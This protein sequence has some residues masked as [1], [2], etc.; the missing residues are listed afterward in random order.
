MVNKPEDCG[1]GSTANLSEDQVG[2]LQAQCEACE[3]AT[4]FLPTEEYFCVN[5]QRTLP[6]QGPNPAVE[7]NLFYGIGFVSIVSDPIAEQTTV[8]YKLCFCDANDNTGAGISHITFE[9]CPGAP[10]P[11]SALVGVQEA[12]IEADDPFFEF[13]NFK[14]E[15]V[16]FPAEGTCTTVTLVYEGV[17]TIDDLATNLD[18]GIKIGS[19]R[20]TTI[21]TGTV[22]GLPILCPTDDPPPPTPCEETDIW[23]EACVSADVTVTGSADVGEVEVSCI[24]P[25]TLGPCPG[26]P[27]PSMFT[28]HQRLCLKVP[29]SFTAVAEANNETVTIGEPSEESCIPPTNGTG[30]AAYL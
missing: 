5:I 2:I 30:R 1:C 9:L 17:F 26:T 3:G 27:G 6:A 14:I 11:I 20:M 7:Q 24:G 8:L 22:T 28:V 4:L 12:D 10:I 29:I 21:D 18:F 19:P 15:G 16:T 13:P 23:V 25:V